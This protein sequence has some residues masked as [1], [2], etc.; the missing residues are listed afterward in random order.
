VDIDKDLDRLIS[1]DLEDWQAWSHTVVFSPEGEANGVTEGELYVDGK[2]VRVGFANRSA[3]VSQ[4]EAQRVA[5]RLG[6]QLR[7]A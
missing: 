5:D 7:F 3:W 4:Q 6:L 1:A 2:P